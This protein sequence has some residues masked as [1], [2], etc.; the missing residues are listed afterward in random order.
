GGVAGLWA[1]P[2]LV[3]EAY[4]A[5]IPVPTEARSVE[6]GLNLFVA[7]WA[8]AGPVIK[9]TRFGDFVSD[10]V[11]NCRVADTT[12]SYVLRTGSA[13]ATLNPGI[14]PFRHADMVMPEIDCL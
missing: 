8:V 14:D 11:F 4:G 2:Q 10:K 5:P 12:R 3:Q 7:R 13:G 6:G 9:L 1:L